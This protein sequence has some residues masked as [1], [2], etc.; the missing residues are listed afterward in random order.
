MADP[1]A[2]AIAR[3]NAEEYR[4]AL[5]AFE[6]RW[7]AERGDVLRACIQLSN[8]LNQLRLGLVTSPRRLL[9]SA[10]ALLAGQTEP[11]EGL[12]LAALR[13]YA[14]AVRAVI[15]EGLETGSGSVPWDAVPRLRIERTPGGRTL[16]ITVEPGAPDDFA[17]LRAFVAEAT[18]EAFDHPDLTAEQRAENA[19]VADIA[20][21]TYARSL[22]DPARRVLVARVAGVAAG[23]VIA[24]RAAA[25]CPEIDWLIVTP[26]FHGAGVARVLMDAAL[27]WLGDDTDVQLGVIHYNARAIAFYRKYG[28][29]DTGRTSRRH[30][31]PRRLLVRP[32]GGGGETAS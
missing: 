11:Y 17:D 4:D 22:A 6:E 8:A 1:L 14:G 32:R 10:E 13:A 28:F 3:F 20:P 15:P 18:R 7:H 29:A 12:D 2:C 5:L 25:P 30:A 9:A 16:A 24:D 21:D 27:A 31:I 23:F 19:W 26:A